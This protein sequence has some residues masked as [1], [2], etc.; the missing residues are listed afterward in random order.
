MKKNNVWWYQVTS[1]PLTL[2]GHVHGFRFDIVRRTTGEWTLFRVKGG[3]AEFVLAS[4]LADCKLR[5]WLEGDKARRLKDLKVRQQY[6]FDGHPVR[7]KSVKRRGNVDVI[8][9]AWK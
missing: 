1:S 6:V 5:A 7:V 4:G 9:L 8:T 2:R 3:V